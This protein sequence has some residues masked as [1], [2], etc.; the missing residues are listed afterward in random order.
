MLNYGAA[1][2][3]GHMGIRLEREKLNKDTGKQSSRSFL[4]LI[5]NPEYRK[6]IKYLSRVLEVWEGQDVGELL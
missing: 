1:L 4:L 3:T 6:E 5:H 2:L